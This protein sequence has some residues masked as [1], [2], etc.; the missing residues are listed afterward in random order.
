[1]CSCGKG[2]KTDAV[3]SVQTAAAMVAAANA[4]GQPNPDDIPRIN[5]VREQRSVNNAV[6]NANS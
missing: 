5:K 1:M 2:K 6:A 3:T 4:T